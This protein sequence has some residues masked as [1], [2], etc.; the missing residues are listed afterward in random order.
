MP[1]LYWPYLGSVRQEIIVMTIKHH[2]YTLHIQ[3]IYKHTETFQHLPG[4]KT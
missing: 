2:T 1:L 4:N 3:A